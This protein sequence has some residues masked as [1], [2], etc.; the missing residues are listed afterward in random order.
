M[1]KQYVILA[2]IISIFLLPLSVM[3]QYGVNRGYNPPPAELTV[4]VD[5]N[6]GGFISDALLVRA[7]VLTI[8]INGICV[9]DVNILRSHVILTGASGDA[10]FD[11]IVAPPGDERTVT[12]FG[13]NNIRFE[14]LTLSGG[15]FGLSIN[16]TFSVGVFDSVIE[17]T[18]YPIPTGGNAR[19]FGVIAGSA[20][21][22]ILFENTSISATAL[23]LRGLWATNGSN[24]T[25]VACDI[26]NFSDG[27]RTSQGSEISLFGS[28]VQA[29]S[30]ATRAFSGS[31]VNTGSRCDD[32]PKCEIVVN[33]VL[34]AG[35]GSAVA[36]QGGSSATLNNTILT[37]RF[38]IGE[39]SHMSLFNVSQTNNNFSNIRAGSTVWFRDSSNTLE[40][41]INLFEFSNATLD[42]G[43]T[44][45]G[46]LNCTSGADA[47]CANHLGVLD[48][49]SCG[50]CMPPSE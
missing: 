41:D 29:N 7:E 17:V 38:D 45:D 1:K 14:N 20:S 12:I 22:S 26:T 13:V 47:Y 5:C 21:G 16:A 18:G 10:E 39:K 37:G 19:A 35:S 4:Q 2:L 27:V 24:V 28:N 48:G 31:T 9:E 6:D 46:T 25:C 15:R 34:D 11:G 32:P 3:A 8:E 30:R 23:G 36:L 40:G 50:A 33:T 49:S 43:S 42:N 44:I